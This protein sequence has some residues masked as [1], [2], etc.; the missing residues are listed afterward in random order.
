MAEPELTPEQILAWMGDNPGAL[1]LAS[2]RAADALLNG[3]EFAAALT[4]LQAALEI[5]QDSAA[6][7]AGQG[8]QAGDDGSR[9][10]LA[11]IV[12]VIVVGRQMVAARIMRLTPDSGE[13]ETTDA[14]PPLAAA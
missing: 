9:E 8:R 6:T 2:A 3:P 14:G 12:N 13:G 10:S 5:N 7:V 1:R 4:A 11:R